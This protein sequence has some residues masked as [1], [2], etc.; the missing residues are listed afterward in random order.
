MAAAAEVAVAISVTFRS[1]P[2]R[3]VA[4]AYLMLAMIAFVTHLISVNT[5]PGDSGESAIPFFMLTLPWGM[6]L[7]KSLFYSSAW[8]YMAYPVGW[9][10][11]ILNSLLIYFPFGLRLKSKDE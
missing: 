2:G 6:M 11:V 9:L 5:N 10:L 3:Y 4:G 1:K 8:A 7:P